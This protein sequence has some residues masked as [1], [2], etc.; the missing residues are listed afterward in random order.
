MATSMNS[1]KIPYFS[2][3]GMVVSCQEVGEDA[4]HTITRKVAKIKNTS[5][6]HRDLF[7]Y[8]RLPVDVSWVECP[9]H[10][11]PDS[12]SIHHAYLPMYDPHE[13]L[14]Y[15]WDI[16]RIKVPIKVIES[17][18][19]VL[20]NSKCLSLFICCPKA[21]RFI[22]QK[23]KDLFKA[24]LTLTPNGVLRS[25]WKHWCSVSD[26]AKRHPGNGVAMPVFLYGDEARYSKT[27]QDKFIALVIGSPLVF[28]QG[29]QLPK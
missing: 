28:K 8:L 14:A 9:V 25:Y 3:T 18:G 27:H 11:A 23:N 12:T 22:P 6:C 24:S 20:I 10:T 15:L 16:G 13:L 4:V 26:W 17:H 19:Q 1:V 5:N 29:S 7:R 21:V 2:G